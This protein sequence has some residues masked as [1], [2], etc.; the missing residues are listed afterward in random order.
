M[1]LFGPDALVAQA[2]DLAELVGIERDFYEIGHR[3]AR[4]MIDRL[5]GVLT[6]PPVTITL[7]SRPILAEQGG[8][9]P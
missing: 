8:E 1:S 9:K 5:T 2:Q 3:A 7:P 4:L 6:G